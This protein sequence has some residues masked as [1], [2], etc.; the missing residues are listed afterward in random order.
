MTKHPKEEAPKQKPKEN[1]S[2][3]AR[4]EAILAKYKY[5]LASPTRYVDDKTGEERQLKRISSSGYGATVTAVV[6]REVGGPAI[7]GVKNEEGYVEKDGVLQELIKEFGDQ[8]IFSYKNRRITKDN[9]SVIIGEI[10][11]GNLQ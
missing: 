11:V 4:V 9:Q 7:L 6:N 5:R 3:E 10:T 8:I 2:N 1:E